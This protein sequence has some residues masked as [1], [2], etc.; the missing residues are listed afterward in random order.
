MKNLSWS[1]Q[2]LSRSCRWSEEEI[3]QKSNL[4][5]LL[6]KSFKGG[7][8]SEGIFHL[9]QSSKKEIN[10]CPLFLLTLDY[11]GEDS[12]LVWFGFFRWWDQ[13]ENTFW[14]YSTF[15]K[16]AERIWYKCQRCFH[17]CSFQKSNGKQSPHSSAT[18]SKK[19]LVE[20]Y[21]KVRKE[22][23]NDKIF[24]FQNCSDFCEIFFHFSN[25]FSI[26][27]FFSFHSWL[28]HT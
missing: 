25:L 20:Q 5:L 8:I 27:S 24:C 9:V 17:C 2:N 28:P 15:N 3:L 23:L 21:L 10:Y 22:L 4:I 16:I 18:S 14:D 13:I 7:L 6:I 12:D 11:K 26:L 19:K 1:H